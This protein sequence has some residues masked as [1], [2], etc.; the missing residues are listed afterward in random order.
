MSSFLAHLMLNQIMLEVRKSKGISSSIILDFWD[1]M[2]G[3]EFC[4]S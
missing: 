3:F 4:R 2:S 1:E